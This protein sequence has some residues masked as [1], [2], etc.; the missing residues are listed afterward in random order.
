MSNPRQYAVTIS[1]S[2]FDG[3][4]FEKIKTAR[5]RSAARYDAFLDVVD[6]WE[7]TFRQFI[8]L[9]V[10]VRLTGRRTPYDY[11]RERYGVNAEVG[12]RVVAAGKPAVVAEPDGSNPRAS[13][14]WAMPDGD[15]RILPFHPSDI[16]PAA[17]PP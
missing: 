13:Y 12:Q 11:I 16:R 5:S 4:D 2:F 8:D 3:E 17:A 1:G 14:V 15:S 9:V 6:A 7:M 10:S